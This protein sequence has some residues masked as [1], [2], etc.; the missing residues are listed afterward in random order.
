MK[1]LGTDGRIIIKWIFRKSGVGHGLERSGSGQGQMAD[2][3]GSGNE[4]PSSIKCGEFL[5]LLRMY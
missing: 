1:D 2:T 3:F 5:D 4:P